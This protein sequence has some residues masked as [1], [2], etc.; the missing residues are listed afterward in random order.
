MHAATYLARPTVSLLPRPQCNRGF[1]FRN[2]TCLTKPTSN[3][4]SPCAGNPCGPNGQ[5]K[6]ED[7]DEFEC[8]VGGRT[9]HVP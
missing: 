2:A 7:D 6:V 9:V 1:E 3:T 8:E 4:T 5:C